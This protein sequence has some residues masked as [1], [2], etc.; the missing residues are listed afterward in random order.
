MYTLT[1]Y[2]NMNNLRLISTHT[3][4]QIFTSKF[5]LQDICITSW[6]IHKRETEYAP[7]VNRVVVSLTHLTNMQLTKADR[8]L[9]VIKID[10]LK[11]KFRGQ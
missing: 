2:S 11:V 1:T 3:Y 8:K 7:R 6:P 4:A 5:I 10:M 9:V